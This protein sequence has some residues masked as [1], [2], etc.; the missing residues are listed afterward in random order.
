MLTFRTSLT[1]AVMALIVA[2]TALLIA[3]QAL[4]HAGSR[5]CLYGRDQCEGLRAP[6]DRDN[7]YSFFGACVGDQFQC[8]RFR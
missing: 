2:L 5:V 1:F 6:S 3:I 8:G 4:G 7:R